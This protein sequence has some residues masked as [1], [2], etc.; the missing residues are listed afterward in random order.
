M[1]RRARY[2]VALLVAALATVLVVLTTRS[3]P[4][5]LGVFATYALATATVL[6]SPALVWGVDTPPVP[7]GLFGGGVTLGALALAAGVG[8][9]VN[10]G[11]GVLGVGLAALGLGTG[12]WLGAAAPE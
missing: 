1:D 10:L 6:R 9:A 12:Y 8:P 7:S 5:L 4:L 11:A 3:L 2:A